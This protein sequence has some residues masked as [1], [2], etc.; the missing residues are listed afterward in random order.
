MEQADSGSCPLP[1]QISLGLPEDF[2][3]IAK[4]G[5]GGGFL[6]LKSHIICSSKK[7][8]MK[9]KV[10]IVCF[11]LNSIFLIDPKNDDCA[12]GKDAHGFLFFFFFFAIW[13][14][15]FPLLFF[16]FSPLCLFLS[17]P[18]CHASFAPSHLGYAHLIWIWLHFQDRV[19]KRLF[20]KTKIYAFVELWKL[21]MSFL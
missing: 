5:V 20:W 11:S 18:L 4:K 15:F 19:G 8:C 16:S 7:S 12:E 10:D 3:S 6:A 21:L 14:P 1:M 13:S 17:S 2:G 9:I